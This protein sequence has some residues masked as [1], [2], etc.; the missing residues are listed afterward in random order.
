MS[1]IRKTSGSSFR[2]AGSTII[3]EGNTMFIK[4][5]ILFF[6]ELPMSQCIGKKE[7]L[8]LFNNFY[9]DYVNRRLSIEYYREFN[10]NSG[11]RFNTQLESFLLMDINPC[12]I[13]RISIDCNL[14]ILRTIYSYLVGA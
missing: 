5:D 11:Y 2:E 14:N 7:Y 3:T 9:T 8:Q 6:P 10:S 12:Y 13:D 4:G 1:E